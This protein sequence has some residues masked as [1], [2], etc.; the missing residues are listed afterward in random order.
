MTPDLGQGGC[1]AIEDAVVL[2]ACLANCDHA[3]SALRNYQ[4]RRIPRTSGLVLR[5]RRIG[6]MAQWENP[7]L[8]FVRNAAVRAVPTRMKARQIAS[9]AVYEAL[10]EPERAF[11]GRQTSQ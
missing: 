8:C 4:D 3:V 9:A 1:Q 11:F 6:A 5:S 7:L 2:A 10:T